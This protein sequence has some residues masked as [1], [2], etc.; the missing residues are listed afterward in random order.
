MA[1][2]LLGLA[3]SATNRGLQ[4]SRCILR[5]F[6]E[7]KRKIHGTSLL[8]EC[9]HIHINCNLGGHVGSSSHNCKRWVRQV[10]RIAPLLG[11][12]GVQM[13]TS[14]AKRVPVEPPQFTKRGKLVT[15]VV[16]GHFGNVPFI[17]GAGFPGSLRKHFGRAADYYRFNRLPPGV[18]AF[19][20]MR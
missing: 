1:A 14:R 13:G 8:H 2:A 5:C 20:D 19:P 12:E 16:R 18:P 3:P 9:I 17:V 4:S 6:V 11:F 15:R 10:N 7:V